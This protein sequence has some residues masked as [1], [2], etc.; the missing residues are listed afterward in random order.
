MVL[1]LF[2]SQVSK[3]LEAGQ[4]K[5]SSEVLRVEIDKCIDRYYDWYCVVALCNPSHQT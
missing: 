4:D 5:M 2:S 3:S 1:M